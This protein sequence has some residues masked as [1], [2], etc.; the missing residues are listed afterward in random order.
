MHSSRYLGN[1]DIL[2]TKEQN[3]YFIQVLNKIS[4]N[5]NIISTSSTVS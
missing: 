3:M 1:I 2:M 4:T 5:T